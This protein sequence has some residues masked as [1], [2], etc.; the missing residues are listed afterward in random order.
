MIFIGDLYQL[1]PVVAGNEKS[2]FTS[3]YQTPY[4]Y[5]ARVFEKLSLDFWSWKRYTASTT[6]ISST[7]SIPS[8]TAPSMKPVWTAQQPLPAGFRT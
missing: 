3:L 5:S 1:P 8:A 7:C 2:V 4:F 6:R